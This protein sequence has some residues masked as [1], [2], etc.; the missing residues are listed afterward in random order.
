MIISIHD[1]G[2]NVIQMCLNPNVGATSDPLLL[3]EQ[4]ALAASTRGT[5]YAILLGGQWDL[6]STYN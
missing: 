2:Q 6:V 4:E 3:F 5:W 1:P